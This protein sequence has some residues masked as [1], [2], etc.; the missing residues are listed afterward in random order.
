MNNRPRHTSRKFRQ[1]NRDNPSSTFYSPESRSAPQ[2][3]LDPNSAGGAQPYVG[4]QSELDPA[5]SLEDYSHMPSAAWFLCQLSG[6]DQAAAVATEAIDAPCRPVVMSQSLDMLAS[7]H[8]IRD[9]LLNFDF[10]ARNEDESI[11]DQ[12]Q[13]IEQRWTPIVEQIQPAVVALRRSGIAAH[14]SERHFA[15]RVKDMICQYGVFAGWQSA[16]RYLT[17]QLRRR[18]RNVVMKSIADFRFSEFDRP[19]LD[20]I[21][22][23]IAHAILTDF[24]LGQCQCVDELAPGRRAGRRVHCAKH[25][26][27][28]AWDPLKEPLLVMMYRECL[29]IIGADRFWAHAFQQ[30]IARRW[31]R[32]FCGVCARNLVYSYCLTCKTRLRNEDE[33]CNCRVKSNS[34]RVWKLEEERLML[35]QE[36]LGGYSKVVL[37][38]CS[39]Y[40]EKGAGRC[41]RVTLISEPDNDARAG[42][43]SSIVERRP[44]P[45][46]V[47]KCSCGAPL[48]SKPSIGYCRDAG[49][50][51]ELGAEIG[52]MECETADHNSA[53]DFQRADD[54]ITFVARL[55]KMPADS[56]RSAFI[57]HLEPDEQICICLHLE[58]DE[59]P[60]AQR[61]LGIFRKGDKGDYPSKK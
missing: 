24:V 2:Y 50:I 10:E 17:E 3:T 41:D 27:I 19:E 52:G 12:Q 23:S 38:R 5:R 39:R 56:L 60:E 15:L 26:R 14:K 29:G 16:V 35:L 11:L 31:F 9:A 20:H 13:R 43:D 46:L 18:V 55:S 25:H 58:E 6:G 51:V 1:N 53:E 8:A 32:E 54:W 37:L 59:S 49:Q 45:A 36:I 28:S 22:L 40:R 4:S 30:S 7:A 44:N 47:R 34:C 42:K 33:P 21:S 61:L 48:N 57:R